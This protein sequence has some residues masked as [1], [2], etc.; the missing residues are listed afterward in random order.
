MP[1]LYCNLGLFLHVR[2]SFYNLFQPKQFYAV[3]LVHNTKLIVILQLQVNEIFLGNTACP[4]TLM[5]LLQTCDR[6]HNKKHQYTQNIK[7]RVVE[8][9]VQTR[10]GKIKMINL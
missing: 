2:L 9:T 4:E 7:N 6:K 10:I 8:M 3:G 1:L 5:K